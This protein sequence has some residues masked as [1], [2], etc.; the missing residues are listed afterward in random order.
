MNDDDRESIVQWKMQ[1][2]WAAARQG[3]IPPHQIHAVLQRPIHTPP[4]PPSFLSEPFIRATTLPVPICPFPF[5]KWIDWPVGHVS[6]WEEWQATL[7]RLAE[8]RRQR[9]GICGGICKSP[10]TPNDLMVG[11][12]VWG[13]LQIP[14]PP[15]PPPLPLIQ[16]MMYVSSLPKAKGRLSTL[17]PPIP[18]SPQG[19]RV[20]LSCWKSSVLAPWILLDVICHNVLRQV[21]KGGSGFYHLSRYEID[22][23]LCDWMDVRFLQ[24]M[25]LF[26]SL[27]PHCHW[28]WRWNVSQLTE[29][30]MTLHSSPQQG[31]EFVIP[32]TS[33]SLIHLSLA[34]SFVAMLL[35]DVCMEETLVIPLALLHERMLPPIVLTQWLKQWE[36]MQDLLQRWLDLHLYFLHPLGNR[37]PPL[38]WICKKLGGFVNPPIPPN[39]K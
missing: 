11:L 35:R 7:T 12:G 22:I 3:G 32:L 20:S 38:S 10:H 30:V 26:A 4:T 15:P 2:L 18:A 8:A 28:T 33:S 25:Y 13:D 39:L 19:W 34:R 36:G 23:P 24:F 29:P 37:P 31:A 1:Q 6:G 17:S 9:V 14:P 21:Q 16:W 5:P 27:F